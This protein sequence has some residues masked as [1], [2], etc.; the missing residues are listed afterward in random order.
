VGGGT[1]R[2][3]ILPPI[4]APNSKLQTPNSKLQRSSKS[5]APRQRAGSRFWDLEL[6][7]SLE[8]GVWDLVFRSLTSRPEPIHS[9]SRHLPSAPRS[10]LAGRERGHFRTGGCIKMRPGL[11]GS[12]VLA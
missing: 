1:G 11:T 8:L 10:C 5:Q 9:L 3:E 12:R 4:K 6:G 7:I 2:G